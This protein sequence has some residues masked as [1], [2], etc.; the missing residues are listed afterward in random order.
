MEMI[1]IG[2]YLK[3]NYSDFKWNW[4]HFDGV[5]WDEKT[6]KSSI[7]KFESKEWNSGVD[8]EYGNYDYLMGADI[9]FSNKEVVEELLKWGRWYLKTTDV[10][11]FRLDA[12]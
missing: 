9:D 7:Y 1:E 10:D 11:G 12:G 6:K 2:Q 4:T 5:D 8:S 3:E